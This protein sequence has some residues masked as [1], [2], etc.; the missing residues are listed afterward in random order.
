MV[1]YLNHNKTWSSHSLR[2]CVRKRAPDCNV[3]NNYASNLGQ[4]FFNSRIPCPVFALTGKLQTAKRF[5]K[6]LMLFNL[7]T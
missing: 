3:R 1:L 7:F 2:I 5:K 6:H 4:I